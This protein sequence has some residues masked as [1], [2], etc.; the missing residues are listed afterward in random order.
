MGVDAVIDYNGYL[1]LADCYCCDGAAVVYGCDIGVAGGVLYGVILQGHVVG[2]NNGSYLRGLSGN[3]AECVLFKRNA[4]SVVLYVALDVST[5]DLVPVGCVSCEGDLRGVAG[6][7]SVSGELNG[8]VGAL[9]EGQT[10]AENRGV[11][12]LGVCEKFIEGLVVDLYLVKRGV[13]D[14]NGLLI[15]R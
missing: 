1:S 3:Q 11:V 8:V 7:C 15:D 2:G 12:S 5:G 10:I 13:G 14:G 4:G 6:L 9:G